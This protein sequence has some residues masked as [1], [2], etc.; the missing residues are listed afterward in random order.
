MLN[1]TIKNKLLSILS[2]TASE[3]KQQITRINEED[4]LYAKEIMQVRT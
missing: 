2:S 3:F 4:T 1:I